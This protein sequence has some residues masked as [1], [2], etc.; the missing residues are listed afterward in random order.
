MIIDS[1]R[2]TIRSHP[3]PYRDITDE[4][5][6]NGVMVSDNV[7]NARIGNILKELGLAEARNTGIPLIHQSMINNGSDMVRLETDECR[8]Y[9]K[10]VIPI[11]KSFL[12]DM[13]EH[14]SN[15]TAAELRTSIISLLTEQDMSVREISE[16]LGY[17]NPPSNLRAEIQV[18]IANKTIRYTDS[19][20]NSPR[21]KL[22]LIM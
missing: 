14:M 17:R 15:R 4:D 3:G 7:R 22:H 10:I 21:Q 5:L 8:T 11:H 9:F 20:A 18:L 6:K 19:S 1:D 2:I 13:Q 12:K 16:K